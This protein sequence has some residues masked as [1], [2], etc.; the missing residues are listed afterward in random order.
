MGNGNTASVLQQDSYDFMWF[1]IMWTTTNMRLVIAT[2]PF[3]FLK[4]SCGYIHIL[5]SWHFSL[6]SA[7]NL[8]WDVIVFISAFLY[9]NF[10]ACYLS[11]KMSEEGIP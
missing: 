3:Y 9:F 8:T 7:H 1:I 5:N 11:C 10:A 4:G 6:L 2:S